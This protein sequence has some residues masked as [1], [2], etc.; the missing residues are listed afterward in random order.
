[1]RLKKLSLAILLMSSQQLFA[2]DNAM[3]TIPT[4]PDVLVMGSGVQINAQGSLLDEIVKT[5]SIDAK[6]I[7]RSNAGNITEALD[8]RPGV[9]VQLECSVCN[10]RNITLNNLPGRFTTLFN[11]T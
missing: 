7:E 8:K 5:E 4:T 10:V 1:M 3:L 11:L 2:A 6:T 9:A